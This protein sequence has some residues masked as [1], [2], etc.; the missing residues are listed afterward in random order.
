MVNYISLYGCVII[1]FLKISTQI[2][3]WR[4]AIKCLDSNMRK[5]FAI[6]VK[7]FS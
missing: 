5:D 3:K 4:D 1:S 7:R 2:L 6:S